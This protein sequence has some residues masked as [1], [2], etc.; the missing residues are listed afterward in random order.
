MGIS[1]ILAGFC[2]ACLL[3]AIGYWMRIFK[4]EGTD[5]VFIDHF[6]L[7]F[8]LGILEHEAIKGVVIVVSIRF[9]APRATHFS[10]F[11]ITLLFRGCIFVRCGLLIWET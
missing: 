10:D 2:V 8:H 3:R 1:T 9:C 11:G 5:S 4:A 6:P 7:V